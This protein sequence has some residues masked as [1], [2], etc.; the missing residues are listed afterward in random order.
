MVT[1]VNFNEQKDVGRG[2]R[3]RARTCNACFLKNNT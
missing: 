1:L 2:M 3:A